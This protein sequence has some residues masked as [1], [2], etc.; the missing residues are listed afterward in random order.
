MK[1][2]LFFLF[3]TC[4][5][6]YSCTTEPKDTLIT[7]SKEF[8]GKFSLGKSSIYDTDTLEVK[9]TSDN[10]DFTLI[11]SWQINI[12]QLICFLSDTCDTL[13]TFYP[14]KGLIVTSNYGVS[15]LYNSEFMG[16]INLFQSGRRVFGSF[17]FLD[18]N[19]N[20]GRCNNISFNLDPN[21]TQFPADTLSNVTVNYIL[22]FDWVIQ[23]DGSRELE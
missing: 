8:Y 1:R 3:I 17:F 23:T 12:S 16:Y 20:Y 15:Y 6:F 7:G 2:F 9:L 13:D 18:S 14:T 22:R 5:F 19:G 10:V 21:I 11:P 4:I